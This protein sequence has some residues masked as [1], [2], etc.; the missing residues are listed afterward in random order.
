MVQIFLDYGAPESVTL[1]TAAFQRVDLNNPPTAV[2]GI[3][4]VT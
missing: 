4:D 3:K 2:G 1:L